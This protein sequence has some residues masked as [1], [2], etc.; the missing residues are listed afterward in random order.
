MYIYISVT[1]PDWYEKHRTHEGV[2][3]DKIFK[4]LCLQVLENAIPGSNIF[5]I[6]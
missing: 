6:I 3:M 2:T 1:Y 4:N 5:E